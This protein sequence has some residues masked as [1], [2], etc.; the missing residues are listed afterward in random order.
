LG[1][2]Q[3]P[4][5]EQPPGGPHRLC[6]YRSDD[7]NRHRSVGSAHGLFDRRVEA[8]DLLRIEFHNLR[9]TA[10]SLL[11]DV[12]VLTGDAQMILGHSSVNVTQGIYTEGFDSSLDTA[13]ILMNI[14]HDWDPARHPFADRSKPQRVRDMQ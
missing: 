1:G 4:V 12:G 3:L 10:A 13:L 8:S 7:R 2:G 6:P 14:I 9:R 11:Q 5:T